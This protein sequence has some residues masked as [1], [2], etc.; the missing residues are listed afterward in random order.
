M[1]IMIDNVKSIFIDW[2]IYI[3]REIERQREIRV[4]A[5]IF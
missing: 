2:N 3:E 4:K 1:Y 5:S